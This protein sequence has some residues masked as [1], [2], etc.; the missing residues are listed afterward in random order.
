MELLFLFFVFCLFVCF[1]FVF[2]FVFFLFCFVFCFF[3]GCSEHKSLGIK[4]HIAHSKYKDSWVQDKHKQNSDKGKAEHRQ[5]S[6]EGCS[7]PDSYL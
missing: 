2:V 1:F 7:F 4:L 6:Q 3:L 5:N